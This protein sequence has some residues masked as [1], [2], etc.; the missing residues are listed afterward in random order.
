[1]ILSKKNIFLSLVYN[2]L[3]ENIVFFPKPWYLFQYSWYLL[4]G[5]S[6][7]GKTSDS[8]RWCNFKQT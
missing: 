5:F 8:I 7:E 6:K 2:P 1:M 4:Y 3:T